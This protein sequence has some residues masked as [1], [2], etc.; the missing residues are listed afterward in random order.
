MVHEYNK[1]CA[2]IRAWIITLMWPAVAL[3]QRLV[4][5]GADKLLTAPLVW[6]SS[7]TVDITWHEWWLRQMYVTLCYVQ[8]RMSRVI[9]D[10]PVNI[11]VSVISYELFYTPLSVYNSLT[12]PADLSHGPLSCIGCIA[13]YVQLSILMNGCKCGWPIVWKTWTVQLEN[14]LLT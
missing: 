7:M 4:A 3:R 13:Y 6:T 11:V 5:L 1:H 10:W 9:S 2:D 8:S 14:C 12:R